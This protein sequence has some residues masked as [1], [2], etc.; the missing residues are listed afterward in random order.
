MDPRG[1]GPTGTGRRN[2]DDSESDS[3]SIIYCLIVYQIKW[4]FE[5]LAL[6]LLLNF[7]AKH[8]GC[9]IE[10]SAGHQ[11]SLAFEFKLTSERR[12][13]SRTLDSLD[14]SCCMKLRQGHGRQWVTQHISNLISL[15]LRYVSY[16][17]IQT[18][19][20]DLQN[21]VVLK[22]YLRTP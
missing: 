9:R 21:M 7:P 3:D 8:G 4:A 14:L 18:R 1:H 22:I 15:W 20:V 11:G 2:S 17:A 6:N 5:F 16:R 13:A 10:P 12:L 19:R